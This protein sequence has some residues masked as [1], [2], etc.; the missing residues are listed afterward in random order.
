MKQESPDFRRG[1]CQK[2]WVVDMPTHET[3][4]VFGPTRKKVAIEFF[5]GTY[6]KEQAYIP[7]NDVLE[8][9]KDRTKFILNPD[10]EYQMLGADNRL[11]WVPFKEMLKRMWE[12]LHQYI[13]W[14]PGQQLE[15]APLALE[16]GTIICLLL[17]PDRWEREENNTITVQAD[18][19]GWELYLSEKTILNELGGGWLQ[20]VLDAKEKYFGWSPARGKHYRT[21]EEWCQT[22]ALDDLMT[23][24]I[25]T[26]P[27]T[28]K[29][30][31][32]EQSTSQQYRYNPYRK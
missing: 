14:K 1:E 32:L 5:S 4:P 21:A 13:Q 15:Y 22:G 19:P 26:R 18:G 20:V 12:K 27:P 25:L 8:Q 30:T 31:E 23:K 9:N 28:P 29:P 11:V 17:P 10:K 24:E 6:P 16:K 2:L 7:I 3:S